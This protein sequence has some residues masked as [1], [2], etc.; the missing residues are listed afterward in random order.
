MIATAIEALSWV[1]IACGSAF[2]L[3]GAVGMLR[4]PDFFSRMQAASVI[5]TMGA[6]LLLTGL[7][8]QAGISLVTLKLFFIVALLFY[9]GPVISHALAQA[10]LHENVGPVLAEDRRGRLDREAGPKRDKED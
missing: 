10:A 9:I 8:L 3:A 1:L 6:G 4:M 2:V 7:M 5:D